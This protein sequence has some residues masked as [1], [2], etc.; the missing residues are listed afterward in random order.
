[1]PH[2]RQVSNITVQDGGVGRNEHNAVR[3]YVSLST[4]CRHKVIIQ[5]SGELLHIIQHPGTEREATDEVS[6]NFIILAVVDS[7]SIAYTNLNL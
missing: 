3:A 5:A 7:R 4:S 6:L 2:H 1:M